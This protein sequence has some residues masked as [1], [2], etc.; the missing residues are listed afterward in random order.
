MG[1]AAGTEEA[2]DLGAFCRAY[3]KAYLSY[4]EMTALLG[5][6]RAALD[7]RQRELGLPSRRW[8]VQSVEAEPAAV[9]LPEVLGPSR[10]DFVSG[11]ASQ[12][13]LWDRRRLPGRGMLVMRMR[14]VGYEVYRGLR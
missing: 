4:P 14:V 1:A 7:E 2:F 9:E 12:W 3:Y 8:L 10:H 5:V 13:Q 6:S 11:R